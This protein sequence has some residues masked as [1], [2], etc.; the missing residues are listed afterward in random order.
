MTPYDAELEALSDK[1]RKGQPIGLLQVL[2]VIEYQ[3]GRCKIKWWWRALE[4]LIRWH[5]AARAPR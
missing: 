3:Q 2:A 4:W 1:V 5:R